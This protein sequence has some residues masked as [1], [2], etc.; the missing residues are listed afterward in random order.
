MTDSFNFLPSL[1]KE[2]N[3]SSDETITQKVL[4]ILAAM[5][6]L[7]AIPRFETSSS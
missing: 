3:P 4:F 1:L 5:E 2:L 7:E 6:E